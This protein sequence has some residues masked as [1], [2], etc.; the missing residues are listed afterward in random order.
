M[1]NYMGK[2]IKL[3]KKILTGILIIPSTLYMVFEFFSKHVRAFRSKMNALD[4]RLRNKIE[5]NPRVIKAVRFMNKY[6]LIMHFILASLTVYAIESISRHSMIDALG[7]VTDT[8]VR[9]L[10]NVMIVFV[11]LLLAYPF[12]C[13]MFI[14]TFVT[15]AWLILGSINGIILANR[16]TPF[17]FTDFKMISDLFAMTN[18]YISI[19]QIIAICAFIVFLVVYMIMF[20]IKSPKFKARP[21]RGIAICGLLVSLVCVPSVTNAAV[22]TDV[23]A[24]YFGNL[25]QGYKD[26][27]FIYSFSASVIDRGMNQPSDYSE[28]AIESITEQVEEQ[29]STSD[30]PNIIF[31]QLESF[32]DPYTVKFLNYSEDPTPNFHKLM[33]NYTSG[34]LQVPVVGAGTANTE[35]EVMTGM[36]I[37]YFGLGEYP[38]KTVLKSQVCE[39]IASD[40]SAIGYSTH[41]VHNNGGNFYGRANVFSNLGY[42]TYTCKEV[43]DIRTYNELGTWATDDILTGEIEKCLDSSEDQA[44]YVYTITV[45]S[46]GSYPSYQVFEDPEIEVTGAETEEEN[47]QW[48]YFINEIHEVDTFIGELVEMLSERDEDTM[49]VLYGDHL[50]TMGLTE[51]DMTTGSLYDTQYV[52]WNNF[53]LE[54]QDKDVTTYQLTSYITD[55]LDIHE[56]TIFTYE[57]ENNVYDSSDEDYKEYKNNL[58]LLQYDIL[59]GNNYVYDGSE[60]AP[61][62]SDIVIGIDDVELNNVY[63]DEESQT[64]RVY[65][66]NFTQWSKIYLNDEKLSTTYVSNKYLYA[67]DVSID[68]VASIVVNQVGSKETIFRSSNEL[69]YTPSESEESVSE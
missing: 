44:D 25:A 5:S 12:R 45:Q 41:A 39:S 10:Y 60:N 32:I 51:D 53:G 16:V 13:R 20:A 1:F 11:C 40:L 23:L 56:G 52:T 49:L 43:M 22:A 50:P 57:Q 21:R 27:G 68:D 36:S 6:S 29:T 2:I 61:V 4:N 37:E 38:Y 26:Y 19:P 8:P 17:N 65:G 47:Y 31:V 46:H 9:F 64:L 62:A 28:E 59:Y 14:R 3:L 54:Q 18:N 7:F 58:E 67:T 35:F 55:L 33:E 66:S 69:I 24:D 48:E 34:Y 63:Y 30:Q 42:D 15:V